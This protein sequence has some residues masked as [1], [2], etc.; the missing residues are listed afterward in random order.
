MIFFLMEKK[1]ARKPVEVG[2]LSPFLY[3]QTVIGLG[4]SES[5]P[6]R[7]AEDLRQ[8]QISGLQRASNNKMPW[9]CHKKRLRC[10]FFQEKDAI[11]FTVFCWKKIS[12]D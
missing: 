4:I 1:S 5:S 10:I 8:L 9:K 2:S 12:V 11:F 6:I 3:I 7:E